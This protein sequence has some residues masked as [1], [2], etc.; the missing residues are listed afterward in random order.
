[1]PHKSVGIFINV[2]L[3]IS[4]ELKYLIGKSLS[5]DKQQLS[6]RKE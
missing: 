2:C 1:M 6:N 5:E 3:K 4:F